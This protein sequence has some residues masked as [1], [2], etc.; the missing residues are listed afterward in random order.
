MN[1]KPLLTKKY[2]INSGLYENAF[3]TF[4]KKFVYPRNWIMTAVFAAIAVYNLITFIKDTT[5]AGIIFVLI[6]AA[7]IVSIWASPFK[8]RRN[9]MK[10][11]NDFVVND[12]YEM[13]LHEDKIFIRTLPNDNPEQVET[14]PETNK[15]ISETTEEEDFF[16]TP[17]DNPEVQQTEI[18]F[19]NSTLR[20]I[21]KND[22]YMLYLMK[23]IFYV[24]PKKD[25][26]NDEINAISQL[27]SGKLAK[28]YTKK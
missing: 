15:N 19:D 3:V 7:C 27:F 23:S 21:E 9:L 17:V 14:E 11:I 24:I 28:N 13:E 4:Q 12:I 1:D 16:A 10:A 18:R 8:I 25:F 5:T 2:S 6:C 22:Y 20:I 26:S